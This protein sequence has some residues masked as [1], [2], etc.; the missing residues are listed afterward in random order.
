LTGPCR[1]GPPEGF[2]VKPLATP[3]LCAL[4]V[5]LAVV[6]ACPLPAS[7]ESPPGGTTLEVSSPSAILVDALSGEV[8]YEKA[9]DER[10]APASLTKIMTLL[11]AVEALEDGRLSPDDK[12]VC[13]EHAQGYGGTQ[14][15]LEAGEEMPLEEILLAIAVGSANDAS[16]AL[17]E[18][19][20]GT[21]E[22]FV[23]LMN[24]RAR[25]LGMH[26]T[27][28]ENSHGLDAPGHYSTARDMA[29]LSR[30]AARH[31]EL[32]RLTAIYETH[33]RDGETWLV[34]RNRMV[35]F[36]R[37]CDG[38]KTG[39][40][41]KAKYSVAVTAQRGGNRFIAVVMGAEEPTARFADTTKML[42]YAF[43]RFTSLRVAEK[44]RSYGE[45]PVDLGTLPRVRAVAP[46]DFGVLLQKG[47]EEEV[48]REV[49]LAEVVKA[50]VARGDPV[51]VIVVRRGEEEE[52][53]RFVLV[54]DADSGRIGYLAL[55]WRLFLRVLGAG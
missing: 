16:V 26:N 38:L 36:Y 13:T 9:A 30:E 19:M 47:S 53:G 12:V 11:L 50:P 6:T 32:L 1:H 54:S 51:G 22:E 40:T 48:R 21:E 7:A 17:A 28:F 27:H 18:H 15:W 39:W 52:I 8:I 34:N 42:N 35:N 29:L 41:A 37:G 55:V 4:A 49:V 33:I 24:E 2:A 25:E 14:I 46:E 5:V 20:C 10:Y 43:A 45:V 23:A 3:R 44:G 31:P